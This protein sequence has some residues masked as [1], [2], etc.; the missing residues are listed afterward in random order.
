MLNELRIKENKAVERRGRAEMINDLLM[1]LETR[2]SK[3]IKLDDLKYFA[4]KEQANYERAW[5][6][7][8]DE[9]KI[10]GRRYDETGNGRARQ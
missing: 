6:A 8:A 3:A 10:G 7:Y 9:A 5:N 2:S 4:T 1:F